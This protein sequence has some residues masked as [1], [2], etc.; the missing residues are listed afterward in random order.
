MV[1]KP[2]FCICVSIIINTTL[3]LMLTLTQSLR[4]FVFRYDAAV[5]KYRDLLSILR[6][7]V[8]TQVHLVRVHTLC[9]VYTYRQRFRFCQR[10]L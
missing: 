5:E 6:E 3:K 7:E 4:I 2:I 10:Y 9:L 8:T 1:M